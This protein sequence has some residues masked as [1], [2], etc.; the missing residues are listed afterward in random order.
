MLQTS[1]IGTWELDSFT[2]IEDMWENLVDIFF[3]NY[4]VLF[5]L[6]IHLLNKTTTIQQ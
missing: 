4:F 6:F 1:V 5:N 2:N 3:K